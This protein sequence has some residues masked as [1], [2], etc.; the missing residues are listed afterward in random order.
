MIRL[1]FDQI[2]E[3]FAEWQNNKAENLNGVTIELKNWETAIVM[4]KENELTEEVEQIKI[5][6]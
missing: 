2:E 6:S 4:N 1:S 5:W 3:F